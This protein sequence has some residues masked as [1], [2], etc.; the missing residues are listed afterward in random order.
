MVVEKALQH[1]DGRVTVEQSV[2]T[3]VKQIVNPLR[4]ANMTEQA[5]V[6][7]PH[8]R[9]HFNERL[10]GQPGAVTVMMR[11]WINEPASMGLPEILENLVI[12]AFAQ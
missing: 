10:G 7:D 9:N 8:W 11:G 1:E 2:R 3:A 5:L 4:L 6:V 12:M